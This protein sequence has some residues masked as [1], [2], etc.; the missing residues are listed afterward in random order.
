MDI[1]D[2]ILFELVDGKVFVKVKQLSFNSAKEVLDNGIVKTVA[3]SG[4]TLDDTSGLQKLLIPLHLILPSLIRMK[5]KTLG[6]SP[7]YFPECLF[8]HV[9]HLSK[10]G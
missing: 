7:F 9:R 4:H 1:V 3:F 6:L 2:N 8:E 10:V 5:D